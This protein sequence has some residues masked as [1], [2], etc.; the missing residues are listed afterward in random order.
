M[1]CNGGYIHNAYVM[2]K[3]KNEMDDLGEKMVHFIGPSLLLTY[4]SRDLSL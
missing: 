1:S 2:R 3:M 4:F